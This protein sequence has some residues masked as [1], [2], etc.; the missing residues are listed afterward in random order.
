MAE[1][2]PQYGQQL[3]NFWM[4]LQTRQKKGIIAAGA[5]LLLLSLLAT[6]FLQS[7]SHAQELLYKGLDARESA[8]IYAVLQEKGIPA[9]LG[10]GNEILVPVGQ[11]D[12]LLIELSGMGYPQSA[13]S[14]DIFSQNAGFTTTEFEKKQYLLFQ[15]QDR[16]EK[17]LQSIDGVKK[18]IVTLDVP[19]ESQYVWDRTQERRG[20]ASV[21]LEM[22][23]R[24]TLSAQMVNAV[25]H[26][27][28]SAVP[29]MESKDVILV[30]ALS[31]MELK[32]SLGEIEDGLSLERLDFETMIEKNMV[33]KILNVLSIGYQPEDIRVAATVVIDYN[34]MITEQLEYLPGENGQGIPYQVYESYVSDPASIGAQG[35]AGEGVNTD[36][37][38]YVDTN[39]DGQP[40]LVYHT[41]NLDYLVSQMKQQVEKDRAQLSDASLAITLNDPDFNEAKE[42]QIVALAARATNVPPENITVASL[43]LRPQEALPIPLPPADEP[44]APWWDHYLVWIIVG[45]LLVLF[46]T[47]TFFVVLKRR[48]HNKE[49]KAIE[50]EEAL[51]LQQMQAVAE[52]EKRRMRD[53]AAKRDKDSAVSE[54]VREFAQ[55]N[56]DITAALL[57]SW[58]K[59]DE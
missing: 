23:P 12:S 2:T 43:T 58:L 26:L 13:P 35:I 15:L 3:K 47:I 40:D 19:E 27:V 5:M 53:L 49:L 11:K 54:G 17:T 22:H 39:Q 8:E 30:D 42:A 57:R 48:K 29:N 4:G 21:L 34:K 38:V 14:Y 56:P 24:S 33:E 6:L 1:Q 44:L 52:E 36:I 25:K 10:A 32:G 18:A 46:L 31:S 7:K 50:A 37:P 20:S 51:A 45:F 16:I 28:A 41:R 55:E 59:E 9:S